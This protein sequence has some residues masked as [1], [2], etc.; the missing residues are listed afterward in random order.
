MINLKLSSLSDQIVITKFDFFKNF[1]L[2]KFCWKK[3]FKI[4]ILDKSSFSK[5]SKKKSDGDEVK[6]EDETKTML[7][8][9]FLSFKGER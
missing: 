8:K 6:T 4:L 1:L 2:K 9:L 7:G 3:N 5:K